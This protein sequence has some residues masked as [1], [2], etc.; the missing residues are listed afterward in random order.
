MSGRV[1]L[2]LMSGRVVLSLMSGRGSLSSAGLQ[3]PLRV[4][5]ALTR[6]AAGG[7]QREEQEVLPSRQGNTSCHSCPPSCVSLS[8][9]LLQGVGGGSYGGV[10]QMASWNGS[11]ISWGG[12]MW[13]VIIV[14]LLSVHIC[15]CCVVLSVC[16]YVWVWVSECVSGCLCVYLL[17][18]I[19]VISVC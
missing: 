14:C 19:A 8:S 9:E 6:R 1:V 15:M 3:V 2:S 12:V 16:G 18:V 11:L 10:E 17:A 5:G 13:E 4:W 7:L